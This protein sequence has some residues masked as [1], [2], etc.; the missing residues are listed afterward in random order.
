M[1]ESDP[2]FVETVQ[3][4]FDE[5]SDADVELNCNEPTLTSYHDTNSELF[6]A[7]ESEGY[8][9]SCQWCESISLNCGHQLAYCSSLR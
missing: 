7:L 3:E 5:D 4:C 2:N 1:S 6:K 8:S 9:C